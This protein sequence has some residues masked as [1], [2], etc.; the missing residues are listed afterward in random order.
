MPF[1][2]SGASGTRRASGTKNPPPEETHEEATFLKTLGEKQKP[3]NIKLAD[4][5]VVRGWVEYYDRHMIRV[6][7]DGE[8]N[9]FI[10]KHDIVYIAEDGKKR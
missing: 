3:V 6:T 5:Q 7:R 2:T 9:L 10:Y 8:P 1:S 4:G